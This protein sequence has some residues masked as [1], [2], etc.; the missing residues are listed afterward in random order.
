VLVLR[1]LSSRPLHG[2]GV[3]D[4]SPTGHVGPGEQEHTRRMRIVAAGAGL[5]WAGSWYLMYL[6]VSRW[7]HV[8]PTLAVNSDLS[9]PG[10]P[11]AQPG[12]PLL[13]LYGVC[14]V[15]PLVTIAASARL[16][17]RRPRCR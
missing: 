4:L 3:I 17:A 11:P 8:T 10:Q 5:L 7:H 1:V 6:E 14:A 13:A 9:V 16:I 15:A 2:Y 12:L